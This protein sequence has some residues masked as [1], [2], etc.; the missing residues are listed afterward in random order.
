LIDDTGKQVFPKS[1]EK[2][3]NPLDNPVLV[4]EVEKKALKPLPLELFEIAT[5]KQA[6][7]HVDQFIQ[8]EKKFYS[9][10]DTYVGKTVWVK[11]TEKL[12][13]I[14]D[15][16]TLIKQD[17]RS[18]KTRQFDPNDF[19]K[20]FQLMMA[21]YAIQHLLARAQAI[22]PEFRKFI[23]AVLAPH[24]KINYRRALG[25]LKLQNKYSNELMEKTAPL[26]IQYH[27]Y[28]PK[29]CERLLEQC[30]AP[31]DEAIPISGETLELIRPADYF[32]H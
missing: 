29:Q 19:P 30:Q 22:G 15:G 32:T 8:F 13:R 26:A 12:I 21:D 11:G 6:K 25:L 20:N 23:V 7:V 16:Y 31:K 24:A 14:F 4:Q 27:I 18:H 10:P 9:V 3:P 17:P 28:V 5:W 2:S 1:I